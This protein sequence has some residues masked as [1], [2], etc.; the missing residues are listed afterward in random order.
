MKIVGIANNY[1]GMS[2]DPIL[3]WKGDN[4]TGHDKGMSIRISKSDDMLR[5]WPEVELALR[6]YVNGYQVGIAN[7]ITAEYKNGQDVHLPRSKSLP[8]FCP[9][10]QIWQQNV[11]KNAYLECYVDGVV[12]Q[13]DS[14]EN[15]KMNPEECIAFVEKYLTLWPGDIIITGTPPHPYWNLKDGDVVTCEIEGLGFIENQ[16][17]M[18]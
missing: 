1:K 17:Y 16:V 18:G 11:K 10:S 8:T 12:I 3:F 6:K 7:D 5:V 14:L 15:M 4:F 13:R 9:L 2:G